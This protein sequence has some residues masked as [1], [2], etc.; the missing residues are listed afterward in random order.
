MN[1]KEAVNKYK[2]NGWVAIKVAPQS[3]SPTTP[4]WPDTALSDVN[5][6]TF[7]ENSNIGILLG[8]PSNG[9][10]DIDL[11]CKEAV[12][13]AP[14]L[15]PKTNLIF[16]R[17]SKKSSHYLYQVADAGS[18]HKYQANKATLLE[19]RS[20][21]SQTI[22]PPSINPS[23][24]LVEFVSDG[25]PTQISRQELTQAASRL[26]S[27]C[28]IAQHW[29]S[30]VR[31]DLALA[32]AGGLL[33]SG[34]SEDSI[35]D[36]ITAVCAA[37]EDTELADRLD[38]IKSTTQRKALKQPV[39]GWPSFAEL[40]GLDTITQLTEWLGVALSKEDKKSLPSEFGMTDLG[41][42]ERFV[43]QHGEVLRHGQDMNVWLAWNGS[44]WSVDA[45]NEAA[46]M[47]QE[48]A[49]SLWDNVKLAKNKHEEDELLSWARSSNNNGKIKAIQ[50]LARPQLAIHS[51]KL[52]SHPFL[53]NCT[54]GTLNL[55]TGS[56]KPFD[57]HDW[58][59]K[60]VGITFDKQASCPTFKAFLEKIFNKDVE[61][62]EFVQ[63]AI[64]YSLSGSTGEQ[65]L[66]ITYGTGANGKSTLLNILR[67][68][69]GE[70]GCTT[71]METLIAKKANGAVPNDIARLRGM[72][73]VTASEGEA[74]QK[75][76]ASLIKQ[77][78]GGDPMTARFLHKE[79][80][81]F[82]PECKLW[83]A[84]NHKPKMKGNDPAIWRRVFLLPFNVTIPKAEQ[85][86][87]LPE[88]LKAELEGIL[89]WAV[90]GFQK[91]QKDGLR[92]PKAVT[93][94]VAE[95]QLEMDYVKRFAD[96]VLIP[97]PGKNLSK[98]EV[99]SAYQKWIQENDGEDIRMPEFNKE[100]ERLGYKAK[101]ST[102][103]KHVWQN[104]GFEL[105]HAGVQI[106][107]EDAP[108]TH[109]IQ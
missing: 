92:P 32:L 55:E 14:H 22:F 50:E 70:Y 37:S 17:Q 76:A 10:V 87:A 63:R 97:M 78:T 84:T 1:V 72:R 21:G 79:Y 52:D 59:T 67:E 102:G 89:A 66:F 73:L 7:D 93:A 9:L 45:K 57:K 28:L 4:N 100:L 19:Y 42:A 31:H 86:P 27:A 75:I 106:H 29:K 56:L 61:L 103:G 65:C 51:N 43:K 16:G 74:N 24:E 81:E 47:A 80:F 98:A 48:T 36:F 2:N 96:D 104:V 33:N 109:T 23:G 44:Y 39:Q 46:L 88:K 107:E 11:D 58:L 13:A 34:W 54:N 82:K 91:W 83:I 40:V 53:L 105:P 35:K 90:E 77:L 5:P 25:P 95:Y 30:G 101:R 3:K 6:S 64:G 8:A 69:T 60:K 41:N 20:T 62:I 85:D 68:I 49:K 108:W 71:P 18:T 26:A 94:A 99:H 38:A 12:L 15:L